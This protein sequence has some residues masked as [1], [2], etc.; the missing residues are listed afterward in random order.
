MEY[1]YF[2]QPHKFSTFS[3]AP[4]ECE[5]CGEELPGYRGPFRGEEDVDFVCEECLQ[6]GGLADMDVIAN[7]ADMEALRLQLQG[8]HPEASPE[9]L[10]QMVEK[11]Y[12]EVAERTPPACMWSFFLWPAHCGDFARLVKEI[13]QADVA[14]LAGEGVVPEQ[15]LQEHR[16]NPEQGK[17]T[18]E[19]WQALRP[20]SPGDNQQSFDTTAL[21]FQCLGCGTHLV[22]AGTNPA[23]A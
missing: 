17:D 9:R 22:V 11:R 10:A 5:V 13:G 21:L 15:W 2:A 16:L 19:L 1:R 23:A 8:Q 18:H 3:T 14:E 4:R 20:D 6:E 7:P 12:S